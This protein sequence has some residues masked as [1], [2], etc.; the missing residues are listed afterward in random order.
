MI[1]ADR[2]EA[3]RWYQLCRGWQ[4]YQDAIPSRAPHFTSSS[5]DR[6]T[7]IVNGVWKIRTPTGIVYLETMRF[8]INEL[9]SDVRRS[10]ETVRANGE[11]ISGRGALP[12]TL[13]IPN[14]TNWRRS[15]LEIIAEH[16]IEFRDAV[17]QAVNPLAFS[18]EERHTK[19]VGLKSI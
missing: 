19:R 18:F 17:T 4:A 5:S 7:T 8:I 13:L 16:M 3:E 12:T 11:R 9:R 2:L 1:K 15:E 6:K 14:T 10:V